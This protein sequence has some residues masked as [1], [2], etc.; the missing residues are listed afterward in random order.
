MKSKYE[1]N[2]FLSLSKIYTQL[3]P[4]KISKNSSNINSILNFSNISQNARNRF[5]NKNLGGS[6]ELT[7]TFLRKSY[8]EIKKSTKGNWENLLNKSFEI[9]RP[10]VKRSE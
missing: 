4:K 3:G 9:I 8:N 2:K 6:F 7:G 10:S 5:S 1:L